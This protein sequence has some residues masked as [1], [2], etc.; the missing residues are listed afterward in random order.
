MIPTPQP[1]AGLDS[2]SEL[3][4]VTLGRRK[5]GP[6]NLPSPLGGQVYDLELDMKSLWFKLPPST[7]QRV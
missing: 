4:K 7:A 2:I 6:E 1:Q 5:A 3:V